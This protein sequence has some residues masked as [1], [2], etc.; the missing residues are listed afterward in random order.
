[1]SGKAGSVCDEPKLQHNLTGHKSNVTSLEFNPLN[2]EQFAS[3]S[4]DRTI[5]LWNIKREVRCFKFLGHSDKVLAV[6]FSPNGNLLAS[7]SEDR[8]LRLWKPTIKGE[9][10]EIKAHSAAVRSVDFSPDGKY[11]SHLF[12]IRCVAN[13]VVG[14][15]CFFNFR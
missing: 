15:T 11:V 8:T 3:S 6:T 5:I 13:L 14:T 1:M 10:F 7:A 2:R 12:R 4:K 9:S